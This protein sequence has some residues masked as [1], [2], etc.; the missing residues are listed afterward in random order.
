MLCACFLSACA[1]PKAMP[2]PV[3]TPV[4]RPIPTETM[5]FEPGMA[6]LADNLAGQLEISDLGNVLN[7]VIVDP[8]TGK[9][10][11]KRIV[12]D[13][14]IDTESGY[15]I[16][17][18]ARI[19]AI[20]AAEMAKRF[21]VTGEMAP[22]NLEVSEYVLCGM[23]SLE[24]L[25]NKKKEVYKVYAA[26]FEKNS[27]VVHASAELRIDRLETAPKDIY[28]DSSVYLKGPSFDEH[29]SSV[30]KKLNETV[31]K[32]YHDKLEAKSFSVK[33]DRLYDEKD[34]GTSLAYYNKAAEKTGSP[35][36][37][38]L[39]G[40][41]TNLVHQGRLDSAELVFGK[42]LLASVTQTGQIATK[43]TFSPNSSKPLATK[44]A[45][46]MI[47]V[48]QIA[49]LMASTPTCKV[50]IVGHCSRSASEEYNDKLSLLRASS[51]Q[52]MMS[53]LAPAIAGRIQIVGRGFRD[54]IV[55]NGS[56]DDTDQYDRRVE[57]K[58]NS[59]LP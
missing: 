29:V 44:A 36:L 58:F 42:L 14:F 10:S 32:G 19:N 1:E 4:P 12:I 31:E 47:Y 7:K 38:I 53:S 21:A 33:G 54:N 45:I 3:P 23:V 35:D 20:M 40:Q 8:L 30:Q 17:V 27:G 37:A 43:I 56:D 2:A 39:N 6:A 49:K 25:P 57:F 46:N 18:N 24:V 48:R 51:I 41:F 34:F 59:C 5:G 15:P 16:K 50:T 52:K 13:P 9:G 11:L 22:E 28:R 55:G 26:V